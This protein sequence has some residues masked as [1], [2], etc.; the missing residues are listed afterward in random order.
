M[1]YIMHSGIRI[2]ESFFKTEKHKPFTLL[3]EDIL[4]R[5]IIEVTCDKLLLEDVAHHLAKEYR[6]GGSMELG[7]RYSV[8]SH[9]M[10]LA[11]FALEALKSEELA[12]YLLMHDATEAYIGDV[13]TDV[14][15]LLPDYKKI[16]HTLEQKIFKYYKIDT[17]Y[18]ATARTLDT[19][20][21]LDEIAVFYPEHLQEHF[22]AQ[23]PGIRRLGI[24]IQPDV[25]EQLTFD[26]FMYMAE[27]LGI[28]DE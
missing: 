22:K 18:Y 15:A 7:V 14:K 28:K 2:Y 8:A 26:T 25:S 23:L 6:Y 21:L 16:E 27:K 5:D 17:G 11:N 9:S 13:V 3:L 24:E 19:S 4:T 10:Y 20:I 1:Y 12:R